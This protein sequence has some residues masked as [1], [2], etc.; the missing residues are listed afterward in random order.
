M[1]AQPEDQLLPGRKG[2]PPARFGLIALVVLILVIGLGYWW[3]RPDPQPPKPTPAV[4]P[5][6]EVPVPPSLPPAP[7]IP[8][9]Q[10]ALAEEPA[11]ATE[12]EAEAPDVPVL[13]TDEEAEQ[14]LLSE[15]A[16]IDIDPALRARF[17]G[18]EPL[19][20]GA[21]LV[22]A[23][24]R[25]LL[26]RKFVNVDIEGEFAVSQE[27][28]A[29][30]MDPAGY[31]RFDDV[32]GAVAA[33][34]VE[35]LAERFHTVRPLFERAYEALGLDP[36]DFDNAVIRTLDQV[37]ATPELKKPARLERKSV[38]YT[39][40]DPQLEGLTDLQKQ[41]LRMGPDNLRQLKEQARELRR[42]LL[43]GTQDTAQ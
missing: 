14:V 41:L 31:S 9:R 25:G 22:D 12:E 16:A 18:E 27:G 4:T 15:L 29:M 39:Y 7:D 42:A 13:L 24:G 36:A 8:E 23:L 20:A 35:S 1:R 34:D 17:T 11:A 38:F 40:A 19:A 21:A 33:V 3:S 32:A 26:A 5:E 37:L 10:P 30:Y 6:P 43:Q 2:R 28:D